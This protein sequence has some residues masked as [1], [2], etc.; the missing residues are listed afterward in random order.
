MRRT[1]LI[2]TTLVL[3]AGCSAKTPDAEAA[4]PPTTPGGSASQAPPPVTDA[5]AVA[6][7]VQP[8]TWVYQLT[9]YGDGLSAVKSSPAE[10]A[11]IDLARDGSTGYWTPAEIGALA[12]KTV[13]SYFSIGSIEKY[14]PEAGSVKDLELN[15]WGDW[16]DEHFVKYWDATWWDRVVRPRVDQAIASG[17]TG[18]Y[19]DVP[20]AYEEIDLSLVPGET[21]E[22]LGRKMAE[23]IVKISKYAKEKKPGFRILPQNSPELREYPGYLDAVDGLGIEEL[24][25]LA[26][27]EKCEEDFCG[28]NLDH[29]RALKAAW[30][31]ILAVDYA[32]D[33]AH[34]SD[35][36]ARAK[37]E[38]FAG[39]V[40]AV[41]LDGVRATC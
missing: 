33:P 41:G 22:S 14:R 30:K 29:V 26:T 36:C 18:A 8:R 24:F 2:G 20:N 17:F 12:P 9:G 16:P 28:E 25:Y 15:Q 32:D 37:A 38:G 1:L 11:V 5:G 35:A 21:R 34:R 19:L 39:Y 23:L 13:Y 7:A 10:A 31:I 4:P 40:G 3:L 27:D 6:P